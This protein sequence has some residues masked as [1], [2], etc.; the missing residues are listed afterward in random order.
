MVQ[1]ALV[2]MLAGVVAPMALLPEGMA[3]LAQVLPFR[4]MVGF[5]VEILTGQLTPTGAL[6]GMAV[7][8]AW[9]GLAVVL[10]AVVWRSGVRRYSAVGG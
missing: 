4:Y 9:A 5:P 7:Q 3:R 2:F 1:D 10:T 8:A 6:T